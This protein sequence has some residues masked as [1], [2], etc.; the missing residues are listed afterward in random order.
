MKYFLYIFVAIFFVSCANPYT[1]E[2]I[3]DDFY[4]GSFKNTYSLNAEQTD[5]IF[6]VFNDDELKHIVNLALHNNSDMFIYD[7]RIKI[8][9]SQVKLAIANWLPSIDGGV[10]YNFNGDSTLD[11]NLM[12]SWELDMFGKNVSSKNAYEE[13]L[14][15]A[16]ENLEYFKI[17]LISDVA[18]AYFNIKYLQSNIILTRERIKNYYDLVS[19]MDTQYKN[20]F[21][22]FSDFLE[23][24]TLLQ[25]EEQTLNT[26]L[27]E[28]EEKKNE[29]RVLINDSNYQFDEQEYN[30]FIPN[31]YV[32]LDNSVSII[33]NRPDIKAQIGN[34]NAAVHNLNAAKAQ[35]YPTI[36]LSGSL[37]KTLVSPSG[38]SDLA[39]SILSSLTLPIFSRME[40]YENIKISDYTRLEA[41]YTLQK[42]IYTALSEIENAI[43]EL[44]ANKN[45]LKTSIE[46]LNDNEEVVAT[47]KQSNELGLIDYVEYLTALNY[48]LSMIKNNNTAYFDTISATIYLY[49]SIGGNIND[50]TLDLED[51]DSVS[52]QSISNNQDSIDIKEQE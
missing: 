8:A 49:R 30:F 15:V 46:M 51:N 48:N 50:T 39:W 14:K 5:S 23:N 38:V 17:S 25:Q 45:T 6:D 18:L 3:A 52:M 1:Q 27:N 41:Y 21:I 22:N 31:F 11:T 32:N 9:Q 19:V 37:G 28:Y 13:M 35:M 12:A 4:V 47:L 29:L 34:L 10:S 24:K 42:A 40:I 2:E 26:L 7:S 44:E 33:L 16:K 20:G 36:S 43:Y